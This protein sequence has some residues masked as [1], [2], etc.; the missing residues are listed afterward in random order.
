MHGGILFLFKQAR[1]FTPLRFSEIASDTNSPHK[2][3]GKIQHISSEIASEILF[4]IRGGILFL[5]EQARFFSPLKF[6][7]IASDTNSPHTEVG[8]IQQRYFLY[9]FL[10]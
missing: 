3:V 7:V 9:L 10:S 4:D 1:S 5:F 2:E 8:K 6:F